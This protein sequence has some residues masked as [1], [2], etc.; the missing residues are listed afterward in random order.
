M[1]THKIQKSQEPTWILLET[2]QLGVYDKNPQDEKVRVLLL[3]F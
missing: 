1:I 2:E 3:L